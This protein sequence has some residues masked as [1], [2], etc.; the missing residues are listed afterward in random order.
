MTQQKVPD[1]KQSE[2]TP[3]AKSEAESKPAPVSASYTS[4][5]KAFVEKPGPETGEALATEL[6]KVDGD[7]TEKMASLLEALG[8]D[9]Y[10]RFVHKDYSEG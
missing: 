10:N 1:P 7:F 5:V 9:A 2:T 3:A 6:D 4:A 8:P